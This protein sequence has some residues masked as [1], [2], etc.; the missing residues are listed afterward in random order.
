MDRVV[1]SYL[2]VEYAEIQAA[3]TGSSSAVQ[4]SKALKPVRRISSNWIS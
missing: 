3:N 4:A 1:A 2:A